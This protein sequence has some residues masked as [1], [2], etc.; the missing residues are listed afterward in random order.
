LVLWLV[1]TAFALPVMP[2]IGSTA[3]LTPGFGPQGACMAL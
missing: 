1:R 2:K 3:R